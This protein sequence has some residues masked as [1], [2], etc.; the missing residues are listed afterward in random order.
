MFISVFKY[1][2][3]GKCVLYMCMHWQLGSLPPWSKQ[4]MSAICIHCWLGPLLP[5]VQTWQP[6]PHNRTSV[7]NKMCTFKANCV[8]F[9]PNHSFWFA[10]FTCNDMLLRTQGVEYINYE[11]NIN[12]DYFSWNPH[13]PCTSSSLLLSHCLASYSSGNTRA[14]AGADTVFK[15]E[16][17]YGEGQAKI[18]KAI[19]PVLDWAGSLTI[20]FSLG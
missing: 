7:P 9:D 4:I 6:P 15:M 13:Y 5:A 17:Y 1:N 16:G 10:Y 3:L 14:L 8:L 11:Q 19:I 18:G 12:Y 20:V 2:G